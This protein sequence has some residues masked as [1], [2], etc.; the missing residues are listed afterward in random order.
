MRRIIATKAAKVTKTLTVVKVRP[1]PDPA[2]EALLAVDRKRE[3]H[4]ARRSA[5][6]RVARAHVEHAAD[7]DHAGA[8]EAAPAAFHA[9]DGRVVADR[10]DI[11]DDRALRRLVRS[12]MAVE[13]AGED[14]TRN[15]GDGARLR[16]T[17]AG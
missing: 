5:D 4:V 16:G 3:Q 10:V 1:K 6:E 13:S 11:P 14:D 12:Q 2:G 17:T 8:V 15:R 9:V 7:D